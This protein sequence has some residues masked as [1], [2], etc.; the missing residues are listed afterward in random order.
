MLPLYI[1]LSSHYH[2]QIQLKILWIDLPGL[3]LIRF[4][5]LSLQ[6]LGHKKIAIVDWDVHHGNGTEAVFYDDPDIFFA[7]LHQYPYYPGTGAAEDVGRG[8][9]AGF[10]LNLPMASGFGDDEYRKAFDEKLLP[11]LKEF[12]P[13]ALL[14][15]AGFDAHRMD[16]LAGIE[17]TTSSFEWMTQ[18]LRGFADEYCEGRL[19]S[20]LEG[21]YNL[22]ALAES[23]EAHAA[24]LL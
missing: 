19:I 4:C 20:F 6:S 9:G 11:R 2:R 7:S 15:S 5:I 23:V 13:D 10:T 21:G 18:K 17:L 1:N 14:I 22:N 24:G 8:E 12:H 3:R 16:P